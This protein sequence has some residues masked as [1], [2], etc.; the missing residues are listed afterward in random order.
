MSFAD[1]LLEQ[2][3]HLE[4]GDDKPEAGEF[5]ASRLHGLLRHVSSAD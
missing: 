4:Q 2:A 1:D 3:H 5:A